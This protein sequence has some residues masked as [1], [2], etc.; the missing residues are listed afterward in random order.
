MPRAANCGNM[1]RICDALLPAFSDT[2]SQSSCPANH[3]AFSAVNA[4]PL[5]VARIVIFGFISYS[6]CRICCN[7][8]CSSG[9]PTELEMP[10]HL[11]LLRTL[12]SFL[13]FANGTNSP[14]P[15]ICFSY[16]LKERGQ[17]KQLALQ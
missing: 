15:P 8:G 9:S 16:S 10:K 11:T 3:P 1:S 5:V 12:S 17:K 2:E 7:S 13:S 14:L 6:H 4:V